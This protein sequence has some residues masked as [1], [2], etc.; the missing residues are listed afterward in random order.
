MVWGAWREGAEKLKNLKTQKCQK[1]CL[2]IRFLDCVIVLVSTV[3]VVRSPWYKFMWDN[4]CIILG[5]ALDSVEGFM[6]HVECGEYKVT[7]Y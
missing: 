6:D 5:S 7:S 4:S 3:S 2:E 1:K